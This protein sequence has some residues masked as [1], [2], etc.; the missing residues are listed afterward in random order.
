MELLSDYTGFYKNSVIIF[1]PFWEIPL[2]LINMPITSQ[3]LRVYCHV[4]ERL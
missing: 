2:Y 4:M 1:F 3:F